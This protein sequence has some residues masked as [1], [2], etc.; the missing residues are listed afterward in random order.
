MSYNS[1]NSQ[2]AKPDSTHEYIIIC[3]EPFDAG[4][5]SH[6]ALFRFVCALFT[7]FEKEQMLYKSLSIIMVICVL[8][9]L[10]RNPPHTHTHTPCGHGVRIW[11][12]T[13]CAC[14]KTRLGSLG[15][16]ASQAR[17]FESVPNAG[18]ADAEIIGPP[19][20]SPG[21]SKVPSF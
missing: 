18:T 6:H 5:V 17:V 2:L 4:T 15:P 21:L 9:L 14:R 8:L 19:D 7:V 1:S 16:P 11:P 20:G 3:F 12:T 13:H 10:V